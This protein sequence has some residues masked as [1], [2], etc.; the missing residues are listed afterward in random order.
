M[1][2]IPELGVKDTDLMEPIQGV[3]K[4]A[5]D[6]WNLQCSVCRQRVGAKIQCNKCYTAFHPLCGRIKGLTMDMR[7]HAG[8]PHLPLHTVLLCH[9]HCAPNPGGY[10]VQYLCASS[11]ASFTCCLLQPSRLR[12]RRMPGNQIQ[13]NQSAFISG[14]FR[15]RSVRDVKLTACAIGMQLPRSNPASEDTQCL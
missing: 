5:R 6:R 7:E 4:I 1:Q 11:S 14:H 10:G 3:H 9:K 12:T 8:G 13:P 2:W 15:C